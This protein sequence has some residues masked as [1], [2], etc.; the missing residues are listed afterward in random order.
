MKKREAGLFTWIIAFIVAIIML[1]ICLKDIKY[2]VTGKAKDIN[3]M[4]AAGDEPSVGD[5]VSIELQYVI[6]WYAELTV[7]G[8]GAKVTY[9]CLAVLE[10]GRIISLC[11]KK[12]SDEYNKINNLIDDTYAYLSGETDIP[13]TPVTFTGTIRKIDS[14]ISGYYLM[15]LNLMGYESG[16]YINLDIDTTQKRIHLILIFVLAIIF[17]P[18]SLFMIYGEILEEKEKKVLR[19][20]ALNSPPTKIDNDP[21]FN[22]QFYNRFSS[23]EDSIG[24]IEDKSKITN[25]VDEIVDEPN[26]E[27]DNNTDS[28]S[29]YS[30]KFSLKKDE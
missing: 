3:D 18:L 16:D 30:S 20:R 25:Q 22:Q 14:E 13:P 11:A 27:L 8:R 29:T 15:D 1:V 9:H 26:Y 7:T 6:D 12:Y 2:I 10:D 4:I 17:V 5:N 21:I 24:D 19:E 28:S 23:N